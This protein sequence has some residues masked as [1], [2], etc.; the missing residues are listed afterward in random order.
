MCIGIPVHAITDNNGGLQETLT[1]K[2]T[3]HDANITFFQPICEGLFWSL[4]ENLTLIPAFNMFEMRVKK[5]VYSITIFQF[6]CLFPVNNLFVE[7]SIHVSS[8][9]CNRYCK[10]TGD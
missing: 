7:T 8:I 4:F 2:G 1:G 9:F 6:S 5:T 3:T 10:G